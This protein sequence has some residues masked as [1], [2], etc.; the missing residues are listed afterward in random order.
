M[1]QLN[2]ER[3]TALSS[4]IM[5]FKLSFSSPHDKIN[6]YPIHPLYIHMKK[7]YVCVWYTDMKKSQSNIPMPKDKPLTVKVL[8]TIHQ[9]NLV[10][11][12][13]LNL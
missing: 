6:F 1:S 5:H 10:N 9:M 4:F 3:D 13:Y 11:P 2:W 7:I 12:T 8:V